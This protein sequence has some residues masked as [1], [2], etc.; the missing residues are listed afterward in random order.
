MAAWVLAVAIVVTG[1]LLP[2]VVLSRLPSVAVPDDDK[3]AHFISYVVLAILPVVATDLLRTGVRCALA[4]IP[5]G[6]VLE[7][8]QRLVPGRSFELADMAANTLGA[9][10]GI[11]V[12]LWIRWFS[13]TSA[14]EAE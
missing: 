6:I 7:L 3:A 14:A 10:T 8:L 13:R 4:M 9:F 2:F 5:L 1:S 12:G 11:I